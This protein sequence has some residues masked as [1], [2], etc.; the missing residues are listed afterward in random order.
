MANESSCCGIYDDV[1]ELSSLVVSSLHHR[2]RGSSVQ[3]TADTEYAFGH[4]ETSQI[5]R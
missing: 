5:T 4:V 3:A 2:S 1:T